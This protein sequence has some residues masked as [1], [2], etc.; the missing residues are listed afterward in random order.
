MSIQFI[1]SNIKYLFYIYNIT[2][3][4]RIIFCINNTNTICFAQC[5][6]TAKTIAQIHNRIACIKA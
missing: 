4:V 3:K 5:T 6:I 1:S 2:C